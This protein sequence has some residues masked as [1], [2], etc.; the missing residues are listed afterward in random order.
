MAEWLR[1]NDHWIALAQGLLWVGTLFWCLG[2][3][4]RSYRGMDP[5]LRR[6]LWLAA[7]VAAGISAGVFAPFERWEAL[8]H[9]A[10]YVDCYLGKAN[11][12]G[13][14]GWEGYVTYPLLR[15]FYWALG[16]LFGRAD[17]TPLLALTLVFR[18]V[19]VVGVGWLA[20]LLFGDRKVSGLAALLL[21]VHPWHAVW[22]ATAFNV[23]LPFGLGVLS[24]LLAVQAWRDGDKRLF[25]AAAATGT[26]VVGSRV[27][28]GLFA[29]AIFCLL[30]GLGPTWG[31]S[32]KVLQPRFWAP[33]VTVILL[34]GFA[35]FA[36]PGQLTEQGGYHGIGGYAATV[37]RQAWVIGLLDPFGTPAAL[38][39]LLVASVLAFRRGK[40]NQALLFGLWVWA[41]TTH[42]LLSTFNDYGF[43][44]ALL[45]GLALVLIVAQFGRELGAGQPRL[46][47]GVC[48][49]GLLVVLGASV[50]SLADSAGR[51]YADGSEF[52]ARHEGFR[53]PELSASDVES[54]DCYLITDNERLWSMGLAGS[55]FNLMDP[56]EAVLRWRQHKGCIRWL[57]DRNNYRVDALAVRP[58]VLKMR[59]WFSW[60]L[61]GWVRVEDGLTA[62][63]Y[64]MTEPPWG[65]G[66]DEPLPET[67]F[68]LEPEEAEEPGPGVDSGQ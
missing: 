67:E 32:P 48:G 68:L 18:A 44:Q 21:V 40:D 30:G 1:G 12:S 9:E 56:G 34:V 63:V 65:V 46:L 27:E 53:G 49:L 51:Y 23:I 45:P 50:Q 17:P 6:F 19:T 39:T 54:G 24:V 2:P 36:G 33:A 22:A 55:H 38:G 13:A 59:S 4:V 62:A 58:R 64:R 14:E 31:R 42:V 47:Q 43:R 11:P 7:A 5:K 37:S 52:A 8:G 57:F 28:L 15:W 10:S 60:E 3:F 41:V 61:E 26:L 35:L 25:L 20:W 29:V 16:G 66:D